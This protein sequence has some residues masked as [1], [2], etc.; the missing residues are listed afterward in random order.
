[1]RMQWATA[2]FTLAMFSF[3]GPVTANQAVTFQGKSV[4]MIIP[5][6]A[7][8]GTDISARLFARF[9]TKYLPGTPSIVPQNLPGGGGLRPL[10]HFSEQVKPA[11]L[12]FGFS[13]S[14]EA[15]PLTY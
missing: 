10:T 12:T 3:S 8:G 2:A 6:T 11:G 7:G 4:R 14:T 15:D 13:S 9:F 1:M 5:T